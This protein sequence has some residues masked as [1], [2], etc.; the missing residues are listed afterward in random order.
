LRQPDNLAATYPD[1]LNRMFGGDEKRFWEKHPLHL[2][3]VNA[4]KIRGHLPIAFYC[5]L[6]D[7]LLPGNQNLH[8]LLTELKIDHT[9]IEV[10][11]ANHSMQPLVAAVKHSNLVFAAKNFGQG[12]AQQ[13]VGTGAAGQ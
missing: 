11:K 12:Q 3:Q 2:A 5:G 7:D 1:V 6:A 4:E 13:P 10:E 9:Y 8:K